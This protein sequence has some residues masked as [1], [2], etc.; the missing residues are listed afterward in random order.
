MTIAP[1][2]NQLPLFTLPPS[3]RLTKNS[4]ARNA[5]G[6]VAQELVCEA[7]SLTPIRINGNY[8]CCFD[9]YKGGVYY[10]I[11]SCR[12]GGKLPLYNW[13]MAKEQSCGVDLL[14]AV[15]V[16]NVRRA[17]GHDLSATFRAAGCYIVLA[18]ARLVHTVASNHPTRTVSTHINPPHGYSRKGYRDGYRNVPLSEIEKLSPITLC[19]VPSQK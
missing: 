9:A 16:H 19:L 5:Y 4:H 15:L 13:R 7:L 1:P 17:S 11:K 2:D 6:Q 18:D 3:F 14:Y 10:E 8:D 12:R